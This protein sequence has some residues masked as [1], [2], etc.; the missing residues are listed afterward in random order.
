MGADF[1]AALPT[2]T[3]SVILKFTGKSKILTPG[4][5][6]KQALSHSTGLWKEQECS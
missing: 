4:F 5:V 6:E 3:K 2:S 1:A